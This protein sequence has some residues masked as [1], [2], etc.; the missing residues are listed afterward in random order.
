MSYPPPQG[1]GYPGYGGHSPQPGYQQPP[2]GQYPPQGY[3]PQQGYGAPPPQGPPQ[4]Y[5][6][7]QAYPPQG[8]YGQPP[9]QHGYPPQPPQQGYAQQQQP[10]GAPSHSPYPPQ[11]QPYGAPPPQGQFPPQGQYPPQQHGQ[12]PPQQGQYPPQQH[13][14]QPPYGGPSA[15]YGAP[16]AQ[17][18]GAP[19]TM[20]TPPSP[21]YDPNQIAH[22]D[23]S[24]AADALRKAMKGFGTDESTL[25][26]VL[27]HMTPQEIPALKQTYNQRHHRSLESDI[28]SECSGYFEFALLAILRGPLQQDVWCLNNALKGAGTKE[29]LL[30]DVLIGRSNA[31]IRAIKAAYQQKYRRSLEGDVKADL[32]AKTERMYLMILAASRQEESAPVLPQAVDADVTELHRATEAKTGTE[33]LTV[34]SILTSRSDGQIRAIAQAY[35]H[36]YRRAL[37]SV[38]RSEFA[39]HME[40]A[41]VRMVRS[42][43]DKAMRDAIALEDCMKGPGTKDERLT[44]RVTAVHWDRQHAAQVKGAYKHR[45]KKDLISRIKGETSGDYER[46]LVAML[47]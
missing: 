11:Q 32:S 28:E 12:Y 1:G 16:P 39:G 46:I 45:F 31:D 33:Q 14:Q 22:V 2:P 19:P 44:Q 29:A 10:Y 9:Q 34:C 25:V 18:Y 6:Q 21:G 20:P 24:G 23:M 43:A 17:P 13:Q 27:A 4:G 7:P 38:I 36:K 8:Q 41:L 37:E 15:P 35:E 47:E 3:P 26:R 5:G 42:G 40:D 30:D